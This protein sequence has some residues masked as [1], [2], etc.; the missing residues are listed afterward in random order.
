MS[1]T[2]PSGTRYYYIDEFFVRGSPKIGDTIAFVPTDR[3]LELG[4]PNTEIVV[5]I[6]YRIDEEG[7]FVV[8]NN[9]QASIDS[10]KC[11]PVPLE[12]VIGRVFV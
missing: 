8:G 9:L 2:L 6:V 1:K 3:F 12:N 11:G 4:D 7:L 5:K 10:R